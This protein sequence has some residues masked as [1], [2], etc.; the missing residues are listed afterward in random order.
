MITL[1][2]WFWDVIIYV[3]NSEDSFEKNKV[4]KLICEK[5][6]PIMYTNSEVFPMY[7]Q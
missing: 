3:K 7:L 5:N 4:N 1:L 2:S 6:M